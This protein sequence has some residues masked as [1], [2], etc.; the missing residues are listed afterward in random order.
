MSGVHGNRGKNF[1]LNYSYLESICSSLVEYFRKTFNMSIGV[2]LLVG[3]FKDIE[4]SFK[5]PLAVAIEVSGQRCSS[6][7]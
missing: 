5:G 3:L 7:I 4:E 6:V 1:M 2:I